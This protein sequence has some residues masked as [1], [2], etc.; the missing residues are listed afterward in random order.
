LLDPLSLSET[1]REMLTI[2]VKP[3]RCVHRNL[4]SLISD[5]QSVVLQRYC[6]RAGRSCARRAPLM[7]RSPSW[8][9]TALSW[10]P[11]DAPVLIGDMLREIRR[12]MDGRRS[13]ALP[14]IAAFPPRSR[15]KHKIS[16][17]TIVPSYRRGS[18]LTRS[19]SFLLAF[20]CQSAP[21]FL[22]ISFGSAFRFKQACSGSSCLVIYPTR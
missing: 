2:D 11:T 18:L 19:S 14:S 5:E 17:V 10:K 1:A 6:G 12:C 13:G 4:A 3:T 9:T 8:S 20:V 16:K 22:A 7:R 21:S 15:L